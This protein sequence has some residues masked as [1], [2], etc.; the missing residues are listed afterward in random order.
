MVMCVVTVAVWVV[1]PLWYGGSVV[2][3]V[4]GVQV[5]AVRLFVVMSVVVRHSNWW[6][7]HKVCVFRDEVEILILTSVGVTAAQPDRQLC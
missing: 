7:L 1:E 4:D 3:V 6:I 2:G 5:R